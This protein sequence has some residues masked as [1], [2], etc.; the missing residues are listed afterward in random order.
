M[1][2]QSANRP[3]FGICAAL[4][5]MLGCGQERPEKSSLLVVSLDTVGAEHLRLYGGRVEL[6]ALEALA[7]GGARYDSAWSPWPETGAAHWAMF[8]G[9]E[10]EIHGDVVGQKGSAVGAST[11]AEA[12]RDAGWRT[13]AF[14]GGYTLIREISGIDRGFEHWSQG[15][16]NPGGQPPTGNGTLGR[17]PKETVK[18]QYFRRPASEVVE[19]AA[20]WVAAQEEPWFAFVHLFD[21]HFPYHPEQPDRYLPGFQQDLTSI[22]ERLRP[23]RDDGALATGEEGEA[24]RAI[25][26]GL[27]EAAIADLNDPLE[28]LF[29]AARSRC[30]ANAEPCRVSIVVVADHGESF[31]ADYPFN[32]RGSLQAEVLRVPLVIAGPGIEAH[33]HPEPVSLTDLTPTLLDHLGL[34]V[35]ERQGSSRLALGNGRSVLYA[36]TDPFRPAPVQGGH[37]GPCLSARTSDG[38]HTIWWAD[39]TRE[40]QGG[41]LSEGEADL[42]LRQ[43]PNSIGDGFASRAYKAPIA[44]FPFI[45]PPREPG[46]NGATP[47]FKAPHPGKAGP[48]KAG[49]GKAGPGKAGAGAP[50][51]G[52]PQG[53]RP[54]PPNPAGPPPR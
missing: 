51:V 16:L 30:A 6:P 15:G 14:I 31:R 7:A 5:T 42:L 23:M 45:D 4:V 2:L 26:R 47:R 13:G 1:P 20:I 24:Q 10:P 43:Y 21:A 46:P 9:F 38:R 33:A 40:T 35:G 48:G 27:Y 36:R 50:P 49:P 34:P 3:L 22:E 52:G 32:H 12:L 25:G 53:P 29:S 11:L 39:R 41:N 54:R 8:T 28:R 17:S 19:E 44:P 18:G 37:L